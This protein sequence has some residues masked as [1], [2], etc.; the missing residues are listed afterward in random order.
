SMAVFRQMY[1]HYRALGD[2]AVMA[3]AAMRIG[4]VHEHRGDLP[5]ALEQYVASARLRANRADTLELAATYTSIGA[6]FRQTGELNRAL[7][8]FE[9]ALHLLRGAGH[10]RQNATAL[11]NLA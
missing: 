4:L 9:K 11:N 3:V 5:L 2:T 7:G 10:S 1:D 6:I 8:Y